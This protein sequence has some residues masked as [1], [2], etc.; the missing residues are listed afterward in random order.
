MWLRHK[1]RED[2]RM[3]PL[4]K[5]VTWYSFPI[6]GLDWETEKLYIKEINAMRL[7]NYRAKKYAQEMFATFDNNKIYFCTLTFSEEYIDST[8]SS[9]QQYVTRFLNQFEDYIGTVEFGDI[10]K[11]I[12]FHA[13][14]VYYGNYTKSFFNSREV[15]IPHD[16]KRWQKGISTFE[17]LH[18]ASKGLIYLTKSFRYISKQRFKMFHKRGVSHSILPD[19]TR[20]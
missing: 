10:G 12:H 14:V 17:P 19:D 18:S 8:Q 16:I 20:F 7:R 15:I 2:P 1:Y 3:G 4:L 6:I 13:L 5:K 9:K 11:R